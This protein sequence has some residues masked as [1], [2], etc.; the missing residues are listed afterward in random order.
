MGVAMHPSEGPRALFQD[1][2]RDA[3]TVLFN[4]PGYRVLDAVDDPGGGRRVLVEPV[5]S[6][7]HCPDC[8]FG[9][10]RIHSRPV[11]RVADVAI[12]GRLQVG[13]CKRRVWCDNDS[14]GRVT[15]TQTTD[16]VGLR[17]RITTRL[18][19][20]IVD[21]L[22][23]EARSVTAVAGEVGLSWRAVMSL[24]SATVSAV[25]DPD[26]VPVR[27]LGVDEHRFRSM[28]FV[29][30][31]NGATVK[32]DPWS[33]LFT[34]LDTG[35]VLDV[36]DGRRGTAVRWWLRQRAESWR[37]QVQLVAIDMSAEFRAAIRDVLPAAAIVADHWHV[38]TRANHMVTQ[39]RR[40]RSWDLHARRGR[41]VDPAWRYRTLLTCKQGN[42]S[43]AQRD[44]LD[45][46]LAAD[47]E[48]AVVWAAKEIVIQLLATR[49]NADFDAEWA[50]LQTAVLATDLPE[51]A[52]LFKTLTAWKD[53]IRAFCLTRVTNA[54]TEAAN[55]NAKNIKRAGRGY[56]NDH[57]YRARI[58]LTAT[59]KSAA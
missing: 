34:D 17:S 36:V 52:A 18:A 37:E 23:S 3:A 29:K 25:H 48:L 54:R 20:R 7:G 5:E 46:I 49:T 26:T 16:Q 53:P 33:I 11:S 9:S 13:V 24:V 44:R 50:R 32:I 55:L 35:A 19:A 12:A 41:I 45:Q 31:D 2:P 42:L 4:L 56:V 57:N 6:V 22:G 10:G 47:I 1:R 21:A 43:V 14:C 40:R 8:G 58:L 59:I 15:F 28:R 27:R 38:M 51:P 30:L 39:V